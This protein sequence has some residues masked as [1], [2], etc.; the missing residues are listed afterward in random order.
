MPIIALVF[1]IP[2]FISPITLQ[3]SEDID[4]NTG[5]FVTEG[6]INVLV[7]F[8]SAKS[9][10]ALK[11]DVKNDLFGNFNGNA[12]AF[13]NAGNYTNFNAKLFSG[14][15]DADDMLWELGIGQGQNQRYQLSPE[16]SFNGETDSTLNDMEIVYDQQVSQL[17]LDLI[18]FLENN[19]AIAVRS[20]LSF[21]FGEVEIDEQF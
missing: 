9:F 17:R 10:I 6:T 5:S 19:N 11:N 20:H 21:S 18:E 4:I 13:E 16:I 3:A 14:D 12:I 8:E 15:A 2:L 7:E 1:I